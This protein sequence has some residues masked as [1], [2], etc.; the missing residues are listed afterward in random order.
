M[1]FD[2]APM[3]G[4][5]GYVY[6]N[7]HAAAFG[8]ADGYITPFLAPTQSRCF[9]ARE[10]R[11][12]DPVHNAGLNVT[13]QFIA[14]SAENFIWAEHALHAM[15]YSEVDLNLGCPSGTVTSKCKGS[16]M[17]AHP[18]RMEPFLDAIFSAAEGKISIKTRVG[19]SDPD[20]FPAL[21]E[22]FNRY[23]ISRLIV[24]PRVR[25]DYYRG[26]PRLES[27]ALAVERAR[28][29][30]CYNGD[31]F[32]PADVAALTASFPTVEQVMLGRGV[33]ADPALIRRL[34]GGPA[35]SMD[36]LRE[37]HARLWAGYREMMPGP[38]PALARMK[39]VWSYLLFLF[40]DRDRLLKPIRK[41]SRPEEYESAAAAVFRSGVLLPESRF[42]PEKL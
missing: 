38:K 8:P 12:V 41:A 40:E 1:R 7:A 20:E 33:L 42:D 32:R 39:E 22:L 3:E 19:F 14:A 29:P 31:L 10:L 13:P 17:L 11:E 5:S 26:A 27:F 23:P 21:L 6:R 9:S 37:F 15:G 18:D 36:E 4:V 2:L 34:K 24:H 28:A 35:A 16:G 25:E 30:L